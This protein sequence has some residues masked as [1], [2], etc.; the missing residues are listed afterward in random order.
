MVPLDRALVRTYRLS[1]VTMSLSTAVW[2]QF[3]TQVV[4]RGAESYL[5]IA[6]YVSKQVFNYIC[7]AS[8]VTST[9]SSP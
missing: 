5:F 9:V 8:G 7:L 6:S 2:P 4:G 3:A 1:I